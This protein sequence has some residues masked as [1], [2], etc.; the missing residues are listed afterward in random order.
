FLFSQ[1]VQPWVELPLWIPD[2]PDT[3]GFW[4]VSGARAKAAGLRI[5]PFGESVRDTWDWLRGGGEVVPTPG[6]APFGLD[7]DKER[8]V[9]AARD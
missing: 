9:L 6:A 7:G 2:L 1:G 8:Q 5:R 4:A 3:A